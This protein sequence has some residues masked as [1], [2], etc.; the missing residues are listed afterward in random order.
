MALRSFVE[1]SIY[2]SHCLSQLHQAEYVKTRDTKPLSH[3]SAESAFWK[4]SDFEHEEI[5]YPCEVA[6]ILAKQAGCNLFC[7]P[8]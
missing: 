4:I 3:V 7:S 8:N 6:M 1:L 2:L 5:A